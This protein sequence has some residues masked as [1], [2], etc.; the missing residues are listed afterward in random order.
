[1][2]REMTAQS[3]LGKAMDRRRI[4]LR[5]RWEEVAQRSGISTAHLRNI[6]GGEPASAVTLAGLE[7]ALEWEPGSIAAVMNGDHPL[8]RKA[9]GPDK[10]AGRTLGEILIER[11][12]NQPEELGVSDNIRNDPVALEI[13]EMDLPE[14]QV[15]AM[16]KIYADMRRNIFIEVRGHNKRR[17]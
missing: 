4:Q 16:L 10:N 13:L 9:G 12:I 14:S 6:R 7:S 5:L 8:P 3:D 15:N 11:G 17:Q 2:A 1:M